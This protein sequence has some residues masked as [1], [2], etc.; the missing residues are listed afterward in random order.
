[1]VGLKMIAFYCMF[2]LVLN[3]VESKNWALIAAGSNGWYNYRH[4]VATIRT[5]FMIKN[6]LFHTLGFYIIPGFARETPGFSPFNKFCIPIYT[7]S[8]QSVF[9][10]TFSK[11]SDVFVVVVH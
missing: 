3:V 9:L 8:G 10:S 7:F 6:I 1:M 5:F 4:Q 11:Y 2:S